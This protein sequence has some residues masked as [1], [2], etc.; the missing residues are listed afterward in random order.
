MSRER[1]GSPDTGG[2]M[3]AGRSHELSLLGSTR[4]GRELMTRLQAIREPTQDRRR[5][6]LMDFIRQHNNEGLSSSERTRATPEFIRTILPEIKR[7]L[8][9]RGIQIGLE[10]YE[11]HYYSALD[12]PLDTEFKMDAWVELVNGDKRVIV[13]LDATIRPEKLERQVTREF[14]SFIGELPERDSP[15]YRDRIREISQ[16]ITDFLLLAWE[17]QNA[18]SRNPRGFGDRLSGGR[19]SSRRRRVVDFN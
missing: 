2:G 4:L 6:A 7:E 17:Q 14:V 19:G 18:I 3:R 12:T 8:S 9:N 11:L 1:R 13:P 16:E 10:G 5:A 15:I